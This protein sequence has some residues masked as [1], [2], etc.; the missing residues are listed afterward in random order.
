[1]NEIH[2]YNFLSG[3]ADVAFPGSRSAGVT[4][5]SESPRLGVRAAY[6]VR[7]S[8]SSGYVLVVCILYSV[9]YLLPAVHT[10]S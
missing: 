8:S 10:S 4:N 5:P 3:T 9:Y 2:S 1:M 6:R 7:A